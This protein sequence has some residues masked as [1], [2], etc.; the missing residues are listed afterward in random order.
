MI[1]FF[2]LATAYLCPPYFDGYYLPAA[3]PYHRPPTSYE[4]IY[5]WHLQMGGKTF[6]KS[7]Y[8][9]HFKGFRIGFTFF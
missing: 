3:F 7:V 1:I 4:H 8:V 9:E 6:A 2:L 5:D